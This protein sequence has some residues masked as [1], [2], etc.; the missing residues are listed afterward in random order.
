MSAEKL[1]S[2]K[3]R[4]GLVDELRG[5]DI[6]VMTLYHAG[7]D[8]VFIFGV[9]VPFYR[10]VAMPYLQPLIAGLFIVLSGIACRYS[11]SNLKRGLVTF[12]LG[13]GL[14]AV[15]IIF[16]PGE[17]IYFGILHFMGAA[18]LI[19]AA[20]RPVL[21]KI[22]PLPGIAASLLLYTLTLRLPYGYIG[23]GQLFQLELPSF[24]YTQHFLLPIGFGGMGA[25]YFPVFP[26]IFLY[27]S[28]A[29]LGVYAVKGRFPEWFYKTRSRLLAALGRR[30]IIVYL[31][32]QPI[33]MGIFTLVF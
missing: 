10:T 20:A 7:Y 31:L 5:L 22:P 18:M 17:A 25:D 28:G 27:F 16:M 19:F 23:I 30:T 29:F 14:S 24:L 15:T 3:R 2:E 6:I 11:H 32:H 9:N 1:T 8:L 33:L 13:L 4:A 21:D 12:A 26:H